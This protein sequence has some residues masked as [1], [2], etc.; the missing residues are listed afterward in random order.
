MNK[1]KTQV[2]LGLSVLLI[3]GLALG[4]TTQPEMP[5]G[6]AAEP[7][8]TQPPPSREARDERRQRRSQAS[9][10]S[11]NSGVEMV[12]DVVYGEAK[13]RDGV[14]VQLLMDVAVPQRSSEQLLP[15]VIYVHGGGFRSGSKEQGGRFIE[16]LAQAGYLAASINYRLLGVAPY[17]AAVL[18]V[19]ESV[20]F[21]RKNAQS[22]GID[23]NRIGII[24]VSAGAHLAS[25]IGASS[26]AAIFESNQEHSSAVTCV[27]AIAGTT[28]L[29][30]FM[31]KKRP[32]RSGNRWIEASPENLDHVLRE[33]SPLS[34]VSADDPPYLFLHG[35]AD[36][37]VPVEQS[38]D[39]AHALESENVEVVLVTLE[40]VGHGFKA[41]SM[42]MPLA[43]FLDAQL[44]GQLLTV[45]KQRP[46]MP[47]E[48][49]RERRNRD[50]PRRERSN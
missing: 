47:A 4:Q 3:S 24:G 34:Y 49:S 1:C 20:R 50:Q 41:D 16:S 43:E 15:A 5:T 9:N 23:P 27:V 25:M 36:K 48:E 7:E 28:D 6:T 40:G 33:A 18:D 8:T 42:L 39:M 37:V 32:Q 19:K 46:A 38:R 35:T 29:V 17:P 45:A 31:A 14:P 12:R 2:I 10:V 26:D 21:L 44:N 13:S 11:G 22:L 30:K